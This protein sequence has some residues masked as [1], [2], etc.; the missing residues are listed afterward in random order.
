MT[1]GFETENGSLYWIDAQGQTHRLKR[2]KGDGTGQIFMPH[3]CI[4]VPEGVANAISKSEPTSICRIFMV[5]TEAG[6][7]KEC[8]D[9]GVVSAAFAS[10]E[11]VGVMLMDRATKTSL[12]GAPGVQ[13]PAPGLY[14]FEQ[15]YAPDPKKPGT[16][17]RYYHMGTKIT[18]IFG[19][20]ADMVGK[21][22][23]IGHILRH[24]RLPSPTAKI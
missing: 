19:H 24:S 18:Q 11:R 20:A 9:A 12:G 17:M 1:A 8:Q 4:Y 5:R 3:A 10:G 13:H 22:Y 23:P 16:M 6:K 14:P 15:I 2:S 21:G 7:L